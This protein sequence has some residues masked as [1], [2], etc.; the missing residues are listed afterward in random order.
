MKVKALSRLADTYLPARNTQELPLPRNLD[1]ALHPFERAR[2]YKRALTATKLERMFAKPFVGQLGDGHRD[3]VYCLARN[4]RTTNEVASGAGDGVVKYW[5][6]TSRDEIASIRA[7]HGMVTGLCVCDAG[8]LSAGADKT[9]KLW[10]T[11][12]R[13]GKLLKTFSGQFGFTGLDHHRTQRTFVTGGAEVSLWDMER[14]QPVGNLLWGADNVT[15]VQFSKTETD[16]FA[17]SGSDNAIVLYDIRTSSPVHKVVTLLRA[18]AISWNPMEAYHFALGHE[19]HNAYLWDMRKLTRSLN[20][21]K[22]HVAAVMSVDFSPTGQELVTGSYDKTVRIYR[23][24]DGHSRDIYH[25]KR[26]QHVFS[27]CFTT[28]S[29]YVLSGSDDA[30]VRLWRANAAERST[31]KLGREQAKL[32]YDNKL[33]ERYKHLPEVRRI[34]RHRHLPR[35]VKKAAEMKRVETQAKQRREENERNFS[36]KTA[37]PQVPEKEKH[38]RGTG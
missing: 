26:M 19:D 29:R 7:H 24:R 14:L 23:A 32:N 12:E 3:G 2:E 4:F 16:V 9:V 18:N 20:V 28:D 27:V 1:P 6:M 33:K 22:D 8:L 31:V 36:H 37:P 11:G 21:Y 17:S 34:A 35:V 38:I 5:D 13:E 15:T 10:A 25:T 30:N